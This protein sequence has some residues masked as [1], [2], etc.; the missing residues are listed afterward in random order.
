MTEFPKSGAS[1]ICNMIQDCTGLAFP[2]NKF[3]PLNSS[4][5]HGHMLRIP[6]MVRKVVV[7]RDPRD[8]VISWYHHCL[9]SN[10]T[11]RSLQEKVRSEMSFRNY[12][13][14]RENLPEFIRYM[15]GRA[16][17]PKFTWNEFFDC[18]IE[19]EGVCHTSYERFS[20]APACELHILCEQLGHNVSSDSINAS[21]FKRSFKAQGGRE[22]G[23]ADNTSFVRKGIVGDWENHFSEQAIATLLD[24]T[25]GRLEHYDSIAGRDLQ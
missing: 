16:K 21:V 7:W 8:I 19:K 3:P 4:I 1:W 17:N 15:F 5:F 22:R 18:W 12:E 20:R 11:H 23:E 10:E 14:L 13:N 9:T 25:G 24:A 2:Q 6:E